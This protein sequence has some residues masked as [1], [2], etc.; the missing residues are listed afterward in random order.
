MGLQNK[1]KKYSS[2]SISKS[3]II[4]I[5]YNDKILLYDLTFCNISSLPLHTYTL[6]SS[7]SSYNNEYVVCIDFM[8]NKKEYFICATNY[9]KLYLFSYRIIKNICVCGKKEFVT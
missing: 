8:K 5:S 2:L 4:L 6:L 1:N 3:N 9:G 7:S